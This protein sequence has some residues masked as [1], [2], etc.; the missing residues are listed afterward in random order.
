MEPKLGWR[1][2]ARICFPGWRT[3]SFWLVCSS[4]ISCQ[5][6]LTPQTVVVNWKSCSIYFGKKATSPPVLPVP[7]PMFLPQLV[8][9]PKAYMCSPAG[10]VKLFLLGWWL[11]PST[12]QTQTEDDPSSAPSSPLAMRGAP[13]DMPEQFTDNW[14]SLVVVCA[15]WELFQ[16]L[17]KQLV[18]TE[19]SFFLLR[20]F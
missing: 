12:F 16:C 19:W 18:K 5:C 11:P 1:V 8:S 4:I 9:S 20:N 15:N 2:L 10:S 17:E 14:Q 6:Q 13:K 3:T 7:L